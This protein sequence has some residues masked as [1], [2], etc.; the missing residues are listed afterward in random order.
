MRVGR[1]V[2][3]SATAG[4]DHQRESDDHRVLAALSC[5]AG[6]LRLASPRSAARRPPRHDAPHVIVE[7]LTARVEPS[8]TDRFEVLFVNLAIGSAIR[9]ERR[10]AQH[11]RDRG[12]LDRGPRSGVGVASG[13]ANSGAVVSPSTITWE[14]RAARGEPDPAP[15]AAARDGTGH[16]DRERPRGRD[17]DARGSTIRRERRRV[18]H[19]RDRGRQGVHD[20]ARAWL[21]ASWAGSWTLGPPPSERGWSRQRAGGFGPRR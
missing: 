13:L 1:L 2:F 20:P 9:R 18:Q 15:R 11:G 17:R 6:L 7:V 5:P 4:R 3:G 8:G 14:P 19:G 12:R 16:P 10:R 21:R